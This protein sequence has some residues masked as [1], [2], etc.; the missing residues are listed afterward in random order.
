MRQYELSP[1]WQAAWHRTTEVEQERL[2][3]CVKALQEIRNVGDEMSEQILLAL[4][5]HLANPKLARELTAQYR[6][7][8]KAQ[9]PLYLGQ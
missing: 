1:I 4:A 6:A 7:H 8:L 5:M 3:R 2:R 9:T